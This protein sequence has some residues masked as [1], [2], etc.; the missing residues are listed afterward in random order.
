MDV[1]PYS[2]GNSN[3]LHLCLISD[4]QCQIGKP[5]FFLLLAFAT[6]PIEHTHWEIQNIKGLTINNLLDVGNWRIST[7]GLYILHIIYLL[8]FFTHSH[9]TLPWPGSAPFSNIGDILGCFFYNNKS[10]YVAD[11][12]VW[13]QIVWHCKWLDRSRGHWTPSC[14]LQVME[15][16]DNGVAY[17]WSSR[18]NVGR[19]QIVF[20][21]VYTFFVR[22]LQVRTVLI[23]PCCDIFTTNC[24]F[25]HSTI[26]VQRTIQVHPLPTL[27]NWLSFPRYVL[28]Y[29]ALPFENG[30][31]KCTP[32]YPNWHNPQLCLRIPS[33]V[34]FGFGTRNQ[35]HDQRSPQK[36]RFGRRVHNAQKSC[37]LRAH[38]SSKP[39]N[40]RSRFCGDLGI[41]SQF[42]VQMRLW[43]LLFFW[44]RPTR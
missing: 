5:L 16:S 33:V 24:L 17:T 31:Y 2:G 13:H 29:I 38:T 39:V 36:R 7:R 35:N 28:A 19:L 34:Y 15:T 10:I 3:T 12:A 43:S 14:Q 44:W 27:W 25:S 8:S 30:S 20:V 21:Y 42:P 32:P 6:T 9:N 22:I 37:P 11:L 41:Y 1:R 23:L 40:K 26:H 18:F 4:S